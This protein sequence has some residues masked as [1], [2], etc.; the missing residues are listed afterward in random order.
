MEYWKSLV[1]E[2]IESEEDFGVVFIDLNAFKAVNDELGHDEGNALLAEF[3]TFLKAKFTRATDAT[4]HQGLMSS[5]GDTGRLGGDEFGILIDLSKRLPDDSETPE[6]KMHTSVARLQQDISIF[7]KGLDSSITDL[8]FGASIGA[9][10]WKPGMTCEELIQK[11]DQAMNVRKQEDKADR[12]TPEEA[13]RLMAN[14]P[15]L[16]K[17]GIRIPDAIKRHASAE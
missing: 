13:A 14:L 7:L 6:E 17:A 4:A 2:R 12:L 11:A 3:G 15:L 10:V 1:S 8:N 5:E 16:E 9:A